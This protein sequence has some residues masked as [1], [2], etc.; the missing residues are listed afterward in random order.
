MIVNIYFLFFQQVLA[1]AIDYY[2]KLGEDCVKAGVAVDVFLFPNAHVDVSTIAPVATITGGSVYKY[3]YFDAEKDGRRFVADL[4]RDV[5]RPIVFDVMMRVRTSTG[6]RP[7]GFYGAFFMQNVTAIEIGALDADKSLQVE[8]KYDDKLTDGD[9]ACIQVATLF[10]SPGGK[11]RLRVQNLTLKVTADHQEVFRN[12][13][14]NAIVSHIL[15]QAERIVKERSPKDMREEVLQLSAKILA[16]YREK[17]SENSPI[18]QLIL[19]ENLKLLPLFSCCITKHD[20]LVGGPELTVDDR[21]WMMS[22]IP[23]MKTEDVVRF[24]YP[25]IYPISTLTPDQEALPNRIRACYQ[26]FQ[27]NE[28]YAVDNGLILFIWIGFQTDPKW[29]EDVFNARS[30]ET[31]DSEKV[32][33][34][35]KS[36]F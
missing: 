2:A 29:I 15:K 9:K 30:I 26:F 7:T 18:S 13:D 36:S 8:I 22:L 12:V 32:G 23:S 20:A 1:P 21:S 24:L 25:S 31:L 4:H 35:V 27:G 6:I 5:S 16:G 28:V 17:C 11:R 10:T 33:I 3:Q 34:V 19:P 14:H